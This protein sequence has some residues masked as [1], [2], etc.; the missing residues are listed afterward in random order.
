M[1][2]VLTLGFMVLANIIAIDFM[3]RRYSDRERR[4]E[5]DRLARATPIAA[6]PANTQGSA[7]YFPRRLFFSIASL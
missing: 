7:R 5:S 3:R 6:W 1:D 4:I 2:L